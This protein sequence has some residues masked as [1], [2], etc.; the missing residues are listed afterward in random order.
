MNLFEDYFLN[1]FKQHYADFAGRASRS[2]FWY[3]TLFSFLISIAI[4]IVTG[5]IGAVLNTGIFS[6]LS[7]IYSLAVIV[8]SICLGIRRLHDT[9]K[10][11]WWYLISL[12]PFV[13][14]I[15]LIVFWVMDSEADRNQYGPNPKRGAVA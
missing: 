13:G 5:I 4:S 12:V 15:I 2:E 7:V 8:P 3:F 1:V 11:G 10:S 14:F 9:G 6:F